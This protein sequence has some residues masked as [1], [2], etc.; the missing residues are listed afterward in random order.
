MAGA[1]SAIGVLGGMGP[2]ASEYLYK[3]LIELSIKEFGAESNDSFPEVVLY[4]IPVPDTISS[5]QALAN[6]RDMLVDRVTHL[7][8]LDL[9]CLSI[10]CNTIHVLL[11][12]LQAASRVPF[13]SMIEEVADN[14]AEDG[15]KKVTILGTPSTIRY[16][17]YQTALDK[18]GIESVTPAPEQLDTLEGIIRNVIAGTAGPEDERR[19]VEVADS[20][21]TQGAQGVILGCT[22][23]PLVFPEDYRLSVY[24]SLKILALALLRKYYGRGGS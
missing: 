10:A 12:D 5:D 6:V 23:L 17:L 21:A 20:L 14:V 8:S 4:S 19:I 1:G 2:E 9:I 13:V 22:E 11:P 7:N 15:K 24:N 3:M 18:R 16:R